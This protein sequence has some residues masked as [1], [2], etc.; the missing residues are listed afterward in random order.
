MDSKQMSLKLPD[1]LSLIESSSCA[2][3]RNWM[4]IRGGIKVDLANPRPSDFEPVNIARTLANENRY[5]GNCGPYSVAQHAVLVARRIRRLGGTHREQLAGL[6]HDDTEAITGD[7]PRPVKD[8]SPGFRD[9]E[10]LL[11]RQVDERYGVDT[12]SEAVR[13]ADYAVYYS[14]VQRLVPAEHQWMY[15]EDTRT[16]PEGP[17]ERWVDLMPWGSERA[18]A[19][20]LDEHEMITEGI[21][22][23]EK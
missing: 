2:P 17:L 19:E 1:G 6:H 14:E 10:A 8:A 12:N 16:V 23:Y 11:A 9:L 7:L 20:Y 5:S 13:A 4:G 21:R 18:F 22:R 15:A 3:K